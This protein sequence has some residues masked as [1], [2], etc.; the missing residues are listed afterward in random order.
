M[1]EMNDESRNWRPGFKEE[2]MREFATD[3]MPALAAK[4]NIPPDSLRIV[5]RTFEAGGA[6]ARSVTL[7]PGIDVGAN[8]KAA[9]CVSIGAGVGVTGF[10]SIGT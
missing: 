8:D 3:E 10:I 1:T 4:Y 9:I 7:A 2:K 6:N 5:A